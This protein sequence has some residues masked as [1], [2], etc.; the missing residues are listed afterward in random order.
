MVNANDANKSDRE[1]MVCQIRVSGRTLW[2]LPMNR[3][4]FL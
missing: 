2:M 3:S 4:T 1:V